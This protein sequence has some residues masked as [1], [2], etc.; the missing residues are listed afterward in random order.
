MEPVQNNKECLALF[1]FATVSSYLQLEQFHQTE[2]WREH[3]GEYNP[4][5]AHYGHPQEI[6]PVVLSYWGL[7]VVYQLLQHNQAYPD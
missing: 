2:S 4:Q 5:I 7:G 3:T 1:P 6:N